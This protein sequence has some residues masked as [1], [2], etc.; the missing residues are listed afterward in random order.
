MLNK[1]IIL[2]TLYELPVYPLLKFFLKDFF[3]IDNLDI[4]FK[5]IKI[6]ISFILE[7]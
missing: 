5:N 4:S 2:G 3:K 6:K 1:T 7:K